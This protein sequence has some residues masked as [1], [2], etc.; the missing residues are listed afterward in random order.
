MVSGGWMFLS[1]QSLMSLGPD[2]L[3]HMELLHRLSRSDM[4]LVHHSWGLGKKMWF[5]LL[6]SFFFIGHAV[7]NSATLKDPSV[8][9][10]VSV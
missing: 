10:A 6:D 5:S 1:I 9:A 8:F 7:R 3:I 2:F 4:L